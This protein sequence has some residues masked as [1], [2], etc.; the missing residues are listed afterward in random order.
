M[1]DTRNF[2][3]RD[4]LRRIEQAEKDGDTVDGWFLDNRTHGNTLKMIEREGYIELRGDDKGRYLRLT[5]KGRDF[6]QWLKK[7]YP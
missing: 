2:T 4:A 3:R 1:S 7:Y 6:L 5:Q